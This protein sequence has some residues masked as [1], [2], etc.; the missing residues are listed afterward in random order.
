MAH[1]EGEFKETCSPLWIPAGLV[2]LLAMP[3]LPMVIGLSKILL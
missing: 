1:H 3:A 2:V